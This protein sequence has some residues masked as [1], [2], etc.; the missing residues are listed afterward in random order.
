MLTAAPVSLHPKTSRSGSPP[1]IVDCCCEGEA[2]APFE[3]GVVSTADVD[4]GSPRV[5][6]VAAD[7]AGADALEL[8]GVA[9]PAVKV[10]NDVADGVVAA[11]VKLDVVTVEVVVC[12]VLDAVVVLAEVVV[13]DTLHSGSAIFT[14]GRSGL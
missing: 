2:V 14:R 11:V 1:R 3:S 4:V 9:D 13:V 8:V 5:A 7:C 10:V 12:V 6:E